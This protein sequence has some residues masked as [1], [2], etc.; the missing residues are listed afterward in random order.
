MTSHINAREFKCSVC[1]KAFNFYSQLKRHERSHS[2]AAVWY[3]EI[4]GVGLKNKPNLVHHMRSH[5]GKFCLY[6]H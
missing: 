1:P 3:C 2:T 5:N 4:C 6:L